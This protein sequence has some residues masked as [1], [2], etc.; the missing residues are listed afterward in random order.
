ME[1]R[2]A[3]HF[4]PG[5]RI[6]VSGHLKSPGKSQQLIAS[7]M[8]MLKDEP[9]ATSVDLSLG[10]WEQAKQ[11]PS[12]VS[13]EAVVIDQAVEDG[14]R[15]YHMR[16]ANNRF[17]AYVNEQADSR[18]L[19]R[20]GDRIRLTGTPLVDN[21]AD[22]NALDRLRFYVNTPGDTH[23]VSAPF[24]FSV[25]H[26]VWATSIGTLL[27][28]ITFFWN[29]L[30]HQQVND[31]TQGLKKLSSHLRMSFD[32][33]SEAV[34]ITDADRRLSIWNR[35]FQRLF[36]D[37][38]TEH[39][40]IDI[41]LG[42]LRKRLSDP[43]VF[44]PILRAGE[45]RTANPVSL[46]LE[47]ENPPQVVRAF[48]S[49]IV[50]SDGTYHGHLYTFEDVTEKQRLEAELI[51]SQKMEAIGQLS[52]GVAH[53]FNN[54][55]TIISS[56]LALIKFLDSSAALEYVNAAET[57]V[58]RA[59]ELTQQLLDFSRR[60]RLEIQVVDLNNIVG[61]I[62]MLLRRTFDRSINL[63]IEQSS[64]PLYAC[65]DINRLEQVLIN[66]CI[67][68]RDALKN[69]VGQITLRVSPAAEETSGAGVM[70]GLRS[71]TTDV[72]CRATY[73]RVFLIHSLRP[74]N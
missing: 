8:S 17:T 14:I 55:L 21:S 38:P 19:F 70:R 28:A 13:L 10:S 16:S 54:L 74:R 71:R 20:A 50:D 39:Q 30:L 52:G 37:S 64:T 45:T 33:I 48:V 67:N 42:I 58:K 7:H 53:D 31:R 12:R 63:Q 62:G 26:L 72:A 66:I 15:T 3:E 6:K 9:L 51:Q 23:F 57:A 60:S 1:T 56:N 4:K 73:Y 61:R 27:V 36:G 29:W 69:R 5:S 41:P 18:E 49:G 34:L 32:A 44:A 59:A 43:S 65:V 47:L 35:Q 22:K 68:A 25:N 46:T 11:L 2:F 40:P 24:Q